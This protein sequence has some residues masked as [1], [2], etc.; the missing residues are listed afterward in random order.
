MS[1]PKAVI[2]DRDGTII[3]S[4]ANPT[5]PLYYVTELDNIILK[6]GAKEALQ[7]IRIHK[8]PII[9]ATKQRCIGKKIVSREQVDLINRRVER[10]LD[11]SFNHVLIEEN[12]ETKIS[13]YRTILDLYRHINPQAMSFFDDNEDERTIAE[14]LG[15]TTWDGTT[16]LESVMRAFKVK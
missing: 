1:I 3:H 10:L 6:P 12:S 5:S 11:I 15:F 16:L 2:I 13:L 9:L 7:I 4:S 8:V 14:R